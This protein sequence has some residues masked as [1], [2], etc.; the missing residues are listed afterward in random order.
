MQRA[1]GKSYVLEVRYV[2]TKGTH[3]PRN[4][5]A[6][7]AVYGPGATAQ[8][9][10]RRRV[11]ANCAANGGACQFATIAELTYGQNSTYHSGQMSFSRQYAGGVD[12]TCRTGCRRRSIISRR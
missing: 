6:N 1:I 8:N 2:G 5:D 9:A 4:I 12:S 3:L 7:P 11:Y 10:D